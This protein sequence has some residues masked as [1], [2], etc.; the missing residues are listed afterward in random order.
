M[1]KEPLK[2]VSK[3]AEK[4]VK[5]LQ[6]IGITK[7][8]IKNA[9]GLPEEYIKQMVKDYQKASDKTVEGN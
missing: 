1:N 4:T 8:Q 5:A 9:L 6:K 2:D 3:T 7:Q